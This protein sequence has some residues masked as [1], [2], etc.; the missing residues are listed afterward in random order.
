M[1]Q[2]ENTFT[3]ELADGF[4]S[5]KTGCFNKAKVFGYEPKIIAQLELVNEKDDIEI[6]GTDGRLF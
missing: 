5:S 2:S 4:Y 1:I 3:I 6:V